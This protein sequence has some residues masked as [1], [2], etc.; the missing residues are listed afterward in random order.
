M[1]RDQEVCDVSAAAYAGH[2]VEIEEDVIRL[3]PLVRRERVN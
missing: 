2:R 1:F 3:G